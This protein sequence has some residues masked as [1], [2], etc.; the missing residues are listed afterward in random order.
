[1]KI[2]AVEDLLEEDVVNDTKG[3]TLESKF[4][5]TCMCHMTVTCCVC[6]YFR[7]LGQY[8]VQL[9]QARGL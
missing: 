3:A 4:N 1:M 6:L 8:L 2:M 9:I 5:C 7:A